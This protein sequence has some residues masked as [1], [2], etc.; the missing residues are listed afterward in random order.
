MTDV[1]DPERDVRERPLER[2]VQVGPDALKAMTHPLRMALYAEL[3][4]RR[5]ATA[6]ELARALGESSGQ[7]S[8]HL[9]QL[10]RFGFVEDDPDRPRGRE[11]WWRAVGF[12]LDSPEL[13]ADP[14]TAASARGIIHRIVA[15][16]AQVLTAWADTLTPEDAERHSQVMAAATLDLTRDERM[17]LVEELMAVLDRH[18][19]AV[20]GRT[21]PPDAQRTRVHL[22]VVPMVHP[23]TPD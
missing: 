15:E 12:D 20:R 21:A 1:K 22:D 3:Q 17:A 13:F 6:S 5:S 8:Y 16:R 11:R 23:P 14:T 9:R 2:R 7:T 18:S 19:S 4:R 10:E